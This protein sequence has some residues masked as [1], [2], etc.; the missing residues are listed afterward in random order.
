MRNLYR[1]LSF[2]LVPLG[3]TI[4]SANPLPK[5][6][7]TTAPTATVKNGTY[8]GIHLP[9][10]NQDLFLGIPFAIPPTGAN[11]LRFKNPQSLNSSWTGVKKATSYSAS[12]I[13]YGSDD[14]PYWK[15]SEDCLY[16]NIVKPSNYSGEKL[17]VAFWIHGGG[18]YEG[19]G[20]DQR[21]NLSFI[22]ENSV[23]IGKPIMAV[24]INYRLSSWG[25]LT[26]NEVVEN[27]H[28]NM[29][30]RDQ[31]LALHW[32]Q[33]NIEAFGGDPSKVTIWGESAGG[34]SVGSHLVAY[35]GRDDGLFRAAIME[36]GNPICYRAFNNVSY[37]QSTYNNI[38]NQTGCGGSEDTL[39]CLQTI[40]STTLNDVLN[41]TDLTNF[42]QPI[43]DGDYIQKQTSIQLNE[44][45]FVHVPIIDGANTDE[46]TAFG[47]TGIQNE[48][49]FLAYLESDDNAVDH[50][51]PASLATELSAAYPD[52]P[53]YGIPQELGC[54]RETP[55]SYWGYMYKRVAAF[56]G[57]ATMVGLR[58]FTCQIWAKNS[59]S[60][61]C[62]RFYTIPYGLTKSIGSTHFQEVAF[63]FHNI[64]GVGYT[65]N[66]FTDMPQS[67]KDLSK[68]M[69]S[70]WV[71]FIHSLDPN[72]FTN[73]SS[74]PQYGTNPGTNIVWDANAT[75]LA[76][77]EPDTFREEGINLIND[78]A[79]AYFNR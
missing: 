40:S 70:S 43:I 27:G 34:W 61:Y 79:L 60:A 78:N 3:A 19:S 33:E 44:G 21:Y 64:N 2:A 28:S 1:L 53:C 22:V 5:R 56:A 23:S 9:E 55:A 20:I 18:L 59:V 47:T 42:F 25:F 30:F 57:D 66:P 36:S 74:W 29:G 46:G 65:T 48:T 8:E 72:S 26:S 4:V 51:L 38:V 62:Y 16:L 39:A 7:N 58:R 63:V 32:A 10:Y 24:S 52:N 45:D 17:P 69:S 35:G 71:S 31:R 77:T 68:L 6:S 12:C 41:T 54:E 76:W 75:G 13:G 50:A 73:S 67:Y 11:G 15:L 49:Q 37:Y 14:W